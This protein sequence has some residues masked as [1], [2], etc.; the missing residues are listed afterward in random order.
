M[1]VGEEACTLWE[2]TFAVQLAV[3]FCD[4]TRFPADSQQQTGLAKKCMDGNP[5]WG[6][7]LV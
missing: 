3:P 1:S 7:G 2:S 6:D 5:Q 4:A